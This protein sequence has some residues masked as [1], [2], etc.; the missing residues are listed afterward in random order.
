MKL[1]MNMP[2]PMLGLL[3]PGN[4][5]NDAFLESLKGPLLIVAVA[6]GLALIIALLI[7]TVHRGGDGKRSNRNRSARLASSKSMA[8]GDEGARRK[9][10]RRHKRHRRDHRKR[11]P[12][13]SETGG[14]PPTKSE[15]HEGEET[16]Q[17]Q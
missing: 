13:L 10:R 5:S 4:P 8:S 14:M 3:N 11:N 16:E 6:I 12:T 7:L 9:K 1:F 2:L 15:I 17:D